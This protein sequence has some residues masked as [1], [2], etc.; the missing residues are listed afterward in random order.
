MSE[1]FQRRAWIGAYEHKRVLAQAL[2]LDLACKEQF[3]NLALLFVIELSQQ[4]TDHQRGRITPHLRQEVYQ[5]NASF[6]AR[7]INPLF[8]QHIIALPDALGQ[9]V[10]DIVKGQ[11][12]A[13]DQQPYAG[14]ERQ[15][16][17]QIKGALPGDQIDCTAL[18]I[19]WLAHAPKIIEIPMLVYPSSDDFKDDSGTTPLD[20][21]YMRVQGSN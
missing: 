6:G 12:I 5:L 11:T 13:T 16:N 14:R 18:Q 17:S 15:F 3:I 2:Q 8:E 7:E 1:P 9:R 10:S 20:D 19:G 4:I 21:V